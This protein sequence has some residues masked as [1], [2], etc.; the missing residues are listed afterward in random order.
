MHRRSLFRTALLGGAACLG[1][2]AWA[3]EVDVVEQAL[4][5]PMLDVSK[6]DRAVKVKSLE[7]LNIGDDFFVRAR[8]TDGV[9][10]LTVPHA[11]KMAICYPI[12]L[13]NVA[14]FFIG[15]D[16]RQLESLVWDLYRNQSNYKVQG[17][18]FWVCV[19]AAEMSLLELMGLSGQRP[20]ADF[21]GGNRKRDID[22]YYAS[23]NRGNTPDQEIE[24]LQTLIAGSGVRAV[25]FR[26]GG[27]MSRNEDSLPGRSETLI[28][29]AQHRS[30]H[31][32]QGQRQI[33]SQQRHIF[34]EMRGRQSALS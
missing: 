18:A 29:H 9:E 24:H 4:R 31:G 5:T 19:A 14:P 17:L 25:K 32:V 33:S 20:L 28:V 34:I 21:F 2:R 3:E 27:R 16:A 8:S 7:L 11:S 12:F 13:R 1:P 26:L 15:K 22:V 23:G 30:F 6:L 10:A